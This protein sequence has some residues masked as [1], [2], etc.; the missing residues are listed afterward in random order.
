M[1]EG[2]RMFQIFAARMFEQ[3]VLTAYREKVA[4]E[5]QARLLEELDEE[6]RL[7]TQREAKKAREAAKKKEK[8]KAHKAAKDEEKAKK[9]AEK[10]A[11]ETAAREAEEKRLE[12][13]RQRKEEQ[14]KKREAERKA[15]DEDRLKKEAEKLRRQQEQKEK[16]A[17]AERKAR[18]AKE[19]E[20]QKREDSKKKEREDREAREKET[21][22]RKAK[23]AQERKAKEEQARKDK[24]ESTA[25]SD[26]QMKEKMS[27]QPTPR[28]QPVA[29][30]PGLHPP[31]RGPPLQ[32]PNLAVAT[33][34]MPVKVPS[35]Q[36]SG[37]ATSHSSSPRSQQM[38]NE[39]S[40]TSPASVA[41]AQPPNQTPAMKNV[42]QPP[43]LHHPQPSA[44][45]S[46]LNNPG[47]NQHAFNVNGLPGLGVSAPPNG[48]PVMMPGMMPQMPMYQGPPMGHH[49]RFGPNGMQYPQ[50]FGGPRHFQP[51]Q[52]MPF[53][54]QG[55]V[56]APIQA[57]QNN[58]PKQSHSRQPSGST[59]TEASSQPAPIA[60]PGPIARPSS[61]TPDRQKSKE[62]VTDQE[63]EQIATQ[64][65]SK[66]LLDDS[67]EP[68]SN[69]PSN[70]SSLP[71]VGAPGT[72]RLPFA[73]SFESKQ[74]PFSMSGQGWSGFGSAPGWGAPGPQRAGAPWP[75][76]AFGAMNH[77]PPT[78]QRSHLPRPMA[79]RVML[80]Q[81]CRQ[82]TSLGEK[83]HPV[84]NVLHQLEIMKPPGEPPISM[85]EMLAICDT[86]GN[87]QNGGG[88]FEVM[89]DKARGQVIK[90]TE[91][92]AP[93]RSSVGDIGS[94]V[95]GH[96]QPS[97]FAVGFGRGF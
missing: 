46:P 57:P 92:T 40:S 47:R 79:V 13:Q 55:P 68:L 22:E 33:P 48:P 74:E 83:L 30:P 90:F 49:P 8:K 50:N 25:R 1:E 3:R 58:T 97:S 77:A 36:V 59:T 84:Q 17:D 95:P 52:P 91:D 86:E 51:S 56:N 32:S 72:G 27:Q 7:D 14:R 85:D 94:P 75:Q 2:R 19:R 37:P 93:P 80:V 4:A 69:I 76:Q 65:G 41:V 96:A 9:D 82:M 63:V 42:G 87:A 28:P 64:L 78:M 31:S 23:E 24:A 11:Q 73:S 39:Q 81:A 62:K 60:R 21:R 16:Q 71:P 45:R 88:S 53:H 44:P 67:D 6:N 18:E 12:E 35:R 20:K 26:N 15:A 70:Q 54:A 43:M 61:T 34:V 10:I 5:R 29:L 38:N 66:A 89:M